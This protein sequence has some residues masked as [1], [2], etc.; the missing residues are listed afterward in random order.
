L[1]SFVLNLASAQVVA[2][3]SVDLSGNGGITDLKVDYG[4]EGHASFG[5]SAGYNVVR[6]LAVSA[7]YNYINLGSSSEYGATA[8]QSLQEYGVSA[9]LALIDTRIVVP[10]VLG[11]GGGV[12]DSASASAGGQS[13]S[14]TQSGGYVTV[15][16]GASIYVGHGFGVRPEFRY[17][18]LQFAATTVDGVAIPGGGQSAPRATV[19]IFYQFG[20]TRKRPY[21]ESH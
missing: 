1:L 8:T 11:G 6:F 7:D 19:A 13:A 18:R 12:R 4:K 15:G 14:A 16:G 21:S 2:P 10:Y 3:K 17:D 9:R 5:V 20:G